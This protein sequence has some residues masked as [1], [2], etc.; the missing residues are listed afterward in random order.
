M[1]SGQVLS[2]V[3][4]AAIAGLIGFHF[5]SQYGAREMAEALSIADLPT[6][7]E[8]PSTAWEITDHEDA[9]TDKKYV[10]FALDSSGSNKAT[11]QIEC[12]PGEDFSFYSDDFYSQPDDY[13]V[14]YRID[15]RPAVTMER[16]SSITHFASPPDET[17]FVAQ[18]AG[19]HELIMDIASPGISSR[20]YTFDLSGYDQL[21]PEFNSH[22]N[23]LPKAPAGS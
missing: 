12:Y 6:Q 16:W 5:G 7:P 20:R 4:V 19:G 10:S 15:K 1:K 23:K 21:R 9:M 13:Y 8:K 17:K 3:G 22:C 18:L 2:L 14:T 11:M